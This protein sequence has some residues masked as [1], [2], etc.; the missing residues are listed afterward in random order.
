MAA[1]A[2]ALLREGVANGTVKGLTAPPG[3]N[4]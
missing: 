2:L 3:L 4:D 1:R